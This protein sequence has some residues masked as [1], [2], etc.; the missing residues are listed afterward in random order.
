MH[1]TLFL[2]PIPCFSP[3]CLKVAVGF[4]VSWC[5]VGYNLLQL[6]AHTVIFSSSS[7]LCILSLETV[8]QV[9]TPQQRVPGPSLFQEH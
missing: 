4:L 6:C 2:L 9:R 1:R 3:G 5:L 8:V 7:F